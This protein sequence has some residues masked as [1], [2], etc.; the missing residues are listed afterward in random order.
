MRRVIATVLMAMLVAAVLWAAAVRW[1]L[2]PS[3]SESSRTP[4]EAMNN[5]DGWRAAPEL[6]GTL[7]LAACHDWTRPYTALRPVPHELVDAVA[8]SWPA[9]PDIRGFLAMSKPLH[10]PRTTDNVVTDVEVWLNH[11]SA[12][13]CTEDVWSERDVKSLHEAQH[14]AFFGM[15]RPTRQE[16]KPVWELVF[17]GVRW[18]GGR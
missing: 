6:I 18:K 15:A 14:I 13:D 10:I 8:A 16:G 17:V 5:R 12:V 3:P 2:R 11:H 1:E 4:V 9:R 7:Y